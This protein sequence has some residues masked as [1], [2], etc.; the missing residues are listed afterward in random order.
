M[1]LSYTSEVSQNFK[2]RMVWWYCKL[3]NVKLKI[4]QDPF[5]D[6]MLCWMIFDTYITEISQ[7][8]SDI[9]KLKY[10]YQNN[11]DFMSCLIK[12]QN[13]L[14]G[15]AS[16]LKE[17]SPNP[18]IHPVANHVTYFKRE[19]YHSYPEIHCIQF[20]LPDSKFN[21]YNTQKEKNL[22]FITPTDKS[23]YVYTTEEDYYKD[24]ASSYF[25]V[26]TKKG[27]W[28]CMRHYEILGN[29]CIPFFR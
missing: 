19:L 12:K 24:Y 23:T 22:A 6:F 28:D 18:E 27:G 8:G 29:N 1:V 3:N 26:T 16:K 10:F 21:L 17:F 5:L 2:E 13:S 7:S 20:S 25:A 15:H 9:K 4:W 14:S 11:S